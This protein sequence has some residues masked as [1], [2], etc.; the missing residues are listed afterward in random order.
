[1]SN[2]GAQQGIDLSNPPPFAGE[3][4]LRLEDAGILTDAC[5]GRNW[6]YLIEIALAEGNARTAALALNA[7]VFCEPE[8]GFD[9]VGVG[10]GNYRGSFLAGGGQFGNIAGGLTVAW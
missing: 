3:W 6:A 1:M 7:V 8:W 9:I 10:G 5:D 2:A 4:E